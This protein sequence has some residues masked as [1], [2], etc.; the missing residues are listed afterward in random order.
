MFAASVCDSA[1]APSNDARRTNAERRASTCSTRS[2]SAEA[3]IQSPTATS[4][5]MLRTRPRR[6]PLGS[7][8]GRQ[9]R[10][11]T[12]IEARHPARRPRRPEL[13]STPRRSRH[14]S[15]GRGGR[16]A[17]VGTARD[18]TERA[19]RH[20]RDRRS[21]VTEPRASSQTSD[22]CPASRCVTSRS[23]SNAWRARA[24]TIAGSRSVRG[25]SSC[26][27]PGGRPAR[28]GPTGAPTSRCRTARP[29]TS[30]TCS[31]PTTP[32]GPASRRSIVVYD[33]GGIDNP[34]D[35]GRP[36]AD[37]RRRRRTT[38]HRG[39]QPVRRRQRTAD[40][41]ERSVRGPDRVRHARHQR[42][43]VR[44]ARRPRQHHPRQ[45]RQ[46]RPARRA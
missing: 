46:P 10:A 34:E 1:R 24:R 14:P 16:R 17:S 11:P 19:T 29:R 41:A 9:R 2:P 33:P 15:P 12:A 39:H 43:A 23:C 6:R 4:T 44:G 30:R 5:P 42:P 7:A 3:T 36:A 28:P 20:R 13:R 31:R 18:G 37:L 22:A 26:S 45:G 8:S 40:L 32:T 35:R 27:S 25:W 38:G 21:R